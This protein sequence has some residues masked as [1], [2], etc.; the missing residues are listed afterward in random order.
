MATTSTV[1]VKLDDRE[2]GIASIQ[3]FRLRVPGCGRQRGV[4]IAARDTSRPLNRQSRK[5]DA[6][7]AGRILD[8]S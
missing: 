2:C 8:C 6:G 1:K 4:D 5:V 7:A 3:R